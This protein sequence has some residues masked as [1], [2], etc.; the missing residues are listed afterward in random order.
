MEFGNW[1]FGTCV[2][3]AGLD[4]FLIRFYFK[5]RMKIKKMLKNVQL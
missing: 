1:E 2:Q 3:L 5:Y 4:S